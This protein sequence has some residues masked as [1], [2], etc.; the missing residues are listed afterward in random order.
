MRRT[1][2]ATLAASLAILTTATAQVKPAT[3]DEQVVRTVVDHYLHGLKFNDVAS[4]KQAFWPEAKLYF[5]DRKT[6]KLGQLTQEDWYKDFAA[7]AGK[8]EPG[9]LRIT[10]LE[11][12]GD[13][14]SVK[15]VEEYPRSRYIDYL[16]LVRFDGAWRIVNKVYTSERK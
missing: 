10:A 4:L 12:T 8:E 16:S 15:V 6:G 2:L 5:V 7:S 1:L 3:A 13:I 9:D 11:V 14:A